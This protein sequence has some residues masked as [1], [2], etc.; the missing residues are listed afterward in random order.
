MQ[1]NAVLLFIHGY[2]VRHKDAIKSAAQLQHDL[3]FKGRA[4]AYSWSSRGNLQ[5]YRHDEQEIGKT[6]DCL[7]GFIKT[8]VNEVSHCHKSM[9]PRIRAVMEFM[10]MLL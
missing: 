7:E 5:G 2:N 8:I 10:S 9:F 6:V 3:E 1:V 4:I